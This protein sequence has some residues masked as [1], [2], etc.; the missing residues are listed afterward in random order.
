MNLEGLREIL[1]HMQWADAVV[2]AAALA[3]AEAEGDSALRA[4]LA[5]AHTVQR[6]FLSLWQ[7]AQLARPP[8]EP[9]ELRETLASARSYYEDLAPFLGALGEGE[10]ARPVPIPWASRFA[11]GLGREPAT[12]TLAETMM[13]VAMH[14]TYH[15][16]QVNTRLRELGAEPPLTDYIAW[17]WFGRPEPRW[18]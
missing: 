14:S 4:K 8:S 2:W 1:A 12:P 6:L 16:G 17:V 15:R 5:H 9:P 11:E 13:Q 3:N 7:G 18:P 10:L